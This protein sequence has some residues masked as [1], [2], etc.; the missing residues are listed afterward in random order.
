MAKIELRLSRKAMKETG[1]KEVMIRFFHSSIDL[2]SKSGVF[3]SPDFF[4]YYIDRKRTHNP[5]KP[6]PQNA[7]TATEAIAVKNGWSLRDSG[8]IVANNRRTETEEVKLHKALS[9]RIDEIKVRI[10]EE[11]EKTDKATITKDWLK[12]VID[13]INNPIE[14]TVGNSKAIDIY[15]L[16][17]AYIKKRHLAD[18]HARTYRVIARAISRYEGFVRKTEPKSKDFSFALD[19]VGK[20]EIEDF[21]DYFRNEKNLS[22]EYPQLF[23]ALINNY[24]VGI[25]KGHEKLQERGSNYIIKMETRLKSLFRFAQ[26]EGYIKNNPF[27]GMKIETPKFGTPY[28]ITIAE[29]NKIADADLGAAYNNL[30]DESR[31]KILL[32]IKTLETQRDIFVFQCFI[33]CRVGDL[34]RLTQE[35][36]I[37]GILIYT[38]HKTKDEDEAIQARVPLHDKASALIKKYSGQDKQGRLFPYISQQKYNDAIKDIFTLSGI[39]R[40]VEV[41]NS[42]TGENELRPI[43]EVAS[44]HLARRTFVGNAYFK[45]SDPNIIGKMSGHVEG[46]RAFSRYRKIEDS[47]L[48]D[49]INQIG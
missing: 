30:D 26:E 35:N 33:G 7:I 6:I 38:P 42:K 20:E 40:N 17:E 25:N 18:G 1:R 21:V 2:Y 23:S 32:P 45:V 36:I 12:G 41:R 24:P 27:D 8:E 15:S 34:L 5:K 49:V 37:N 43:N 9:K 16:V 19:K 13:S 29:R 3:V 31:K 11:Y 44:S 39:T 10:I 14:K 28:Y 48:I 47:T 4:E 46:S 22:E